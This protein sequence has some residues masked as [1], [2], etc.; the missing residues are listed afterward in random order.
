MLNFSLLFFACLSAFCSAHVTD[1]E[2]VYRLMKR[3]DSLP[4]FKQLLYAEPVLDKKV[5]ILREQYELAMKQDKKILKSY[6]FTCLYCA[7]LFE[8]YDDC[9]YVLAGDAFSVC[10]KRNKAGHSSD[11]FFMNAADSGPNSKPSSNTFPDEAQDEKAVDESGKVIK[12]RLASLLFATQDDN[13]IEFLLEHSSDG[14]WELVNKSDS[15]LYKHLSFDDFRSANMIAKVVFNAVYVNEE[16]LDSFFKLSNESVFI[17]NTFDDGNVGVFSIKKKPIQDN[18]Q[19]DD[20]EPSSSYVK[21]T[22]KSCATKNG[23]IYFSF[24]LFPFLIGK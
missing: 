24:F 4:Y 18:N 16:T 19:V 12:Y 11:V 5:T 20:S 10:P 23:C 15:N 22:N 7:D 13:F 8:L 9:T 1:N 14:K 3:F 6:D 17:E 21:K 2:R